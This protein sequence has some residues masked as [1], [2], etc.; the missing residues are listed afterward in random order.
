MAQ[1]VL[2]QRA[3]VRVTFVLIEVRRQHDELAIARLAAG[4]AQQLLVRLGLAVVPEL[5]GVTTHTLE[6]ACLAYHVNQV[7]LCQHV[8]SF[9]HIA[10][11]HLQKGMLVVVQSGDLVAQIVRQSI[12]STL[13]QLLQRV[14]ECGHHAEQTSLQHVHTDG[15]RADLLLRGGDNVNGAFAVDHCEIVEKIPYNNVRRAAVYH[16]YR[17]RRGG[18]RVHQS[19]HFLGVQHKGNR[20]LGINLHDLLGQLV[21]PVGGPGGGAVQEVSIQKDFDIALRSGVEALNSGIQH[22]QSNLIGKCLGRRIGIHNH[23]A[24][25]ATATHIN[26]GRTDCTWF[27]FVGQ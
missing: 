1:G 8:A 27:I 5:G 16:L 24:S 10:H 3:R 17:R 2:Q 19:Q 20:H 18:K 22:F 26:Q 15:Q 23:F 11:Q 14:I 21:V 6:I 4:I 9:D 7:R 25:K 13:F 12:G